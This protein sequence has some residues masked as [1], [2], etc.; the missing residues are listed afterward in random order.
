M[1]TQAAAIQ[2]ERIQNKELYQ[3]FDEQRRRITKRWAHIL[4]DLKVMM[5]LW[6]GTSTTAPFVIYNSVDGTRTCTA[7][8]NFSRRPC[9]AE[10]DICIWKTPPFLY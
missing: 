7:L 5:K 6:H 3:Y 1:V 2:V 9:F 10:S 8:F 4:P